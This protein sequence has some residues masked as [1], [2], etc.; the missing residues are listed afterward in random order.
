VS[1]LPALLADLEVEW[2][3]LGLDVDQSLAPGIP[4]QVARA[5]LAVI[6][7]APCEEAIEW[8]A[9]HNGP[10]TAPLE[11]APS[12]FDLLS[13]EESLAERSLRRHMAVDVAADMDDPRYPTTAWWGDSWLPIGRID[14]A[15]VLAIDL[16]A[17]KMSAPAYNVDWQDL[18][19]SGRPV[20]A[21]LSEVVKLWLTVL[22]GDY[23]M[24]IGGHWQYDFAS[25]PAV[26][27][28]SR[29]VG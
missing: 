28:G 25:V 19:A 3:R 27:R 2:K 29:L 10:S 12:G 8:F 1:E 7:S 16:S 9:W 14:G 6:S 18:I 17:D 20:A 23:Y 22:R 11:M 4:A 21:S 5:D 15:A 24:R 26:Y 13:V